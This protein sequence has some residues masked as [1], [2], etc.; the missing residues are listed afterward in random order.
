MDERTLLDILEDD[1][2]PLLGAFHDWRNG[3]PANPPDPVALDQHFDAFLDEVRGLLRRDLVEV[4]VPVDGD[5]GY[6]RVRELP[7]DLAEQYRAGV[8]PDPAT[9]PLGFYLR[10]RVLQSDELPKGGVEID[11]RGGE[12]KLRAEGASADATLIQLAHQYP[13]WTFV[14]DERT[15]DRGRVFIRGSLRRN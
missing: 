7:D 13:Q 1:V 10:S 14:V 6:E 12:F 5:S 8:V 15:F 9:D 4:L 11:F 3:G 2:E